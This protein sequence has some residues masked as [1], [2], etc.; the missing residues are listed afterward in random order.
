[1]PISRIGGNGVKR[2][3]TLALIAHG[4]LYTWATCPA[5]TATSI[6]SPQGETGQSNLSPD[7]I[8]LVR[9]AIAST[10]L[11]LVRNSNDASAPRPRGSAVVVRRDGIVVTNFHVIT[12][13]RTGAL[14]DEIVFSLSREGDPISARTRY[15]LKPLLVNKQY[16]LALLRVD[17]DVTGNSLPKSFTFPTIEIADSRKIKLLDELFIIGFPEKGGST[18]TVNRGAV[19]GKDVLANWIKTDARVIHGNSGGAAVNIEGKLIGIPTKVVADDQPVHRDVDGFPDEVKHFGAVGFLRPSQLVAEMLAQLQKGSEPGSPSAA[20]QVVESSSVISVR[21]VVKSAATGKPIAGALV[22]LLPLGENNITESTLL[23]WSSTNADGE[24]KL[25]KPVPPGRYTLKAKALGHQ[26][27]T[28]E[29][30]IGPS[31]SGLVIEMRA[32]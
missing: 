22:G 19:E 28:R 3:S 4:V 10:G 21:G 24:F 29:V 26:F 18:V 8:S 31:A 23:S 2:W 20:V 27:Y 7:T 11:V 9:Q 14:Y 1:M 25:N 16:D 32:P 15:R 12:N 13:D 17:S 30:E 5:Q 6:K